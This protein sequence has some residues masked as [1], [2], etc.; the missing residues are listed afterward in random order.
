MRSGALVHVRTRATA[1]DPWSLP[2]G[3]D[4]DGL[5]IAVYDQAADLWTLN[6]VDSGGA[7]S[8]IALDG[9]FRATLGAGAVR[10]AAG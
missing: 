9:T 5:M 4:P 1:A 3:A 8:N 10:G 6:G 2:A 7:A